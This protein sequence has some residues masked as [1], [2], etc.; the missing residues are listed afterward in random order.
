MCEMS[1]IKIRYKD[2]HGKLWAFCSIECF[3]WKLRVI[4][5]DATKT[6]EEAHEILRKG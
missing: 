3:L 5:K 2:N 1:E 6:I 4:I